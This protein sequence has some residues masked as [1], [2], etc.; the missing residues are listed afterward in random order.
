MS[1]PMMTFD[2]LNAL[3]PKLRDRIDRDEAEYGCQYLPVM[4]ADEAKSRMARI[5]DE[6]E[7]R[8]LTKQERFL[9]GQLIGSFQ[10]AVTAEAQ[11][12]KGRWICIHESGLQEIIDQL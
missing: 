12:L 1:R 11:G 8:L 3:L 4:T 7:F 5:V 9:L 2:E 6:T 10:L